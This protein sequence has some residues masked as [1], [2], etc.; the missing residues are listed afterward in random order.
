[1]NEMAMY[2]GSNNRETLAGVVEELQR[3]M[4]SRVIA[5][6]RVRR[7]IEDPLVTRGK[8][9]LRRDEAAFQAN[10]ELLQSLINTFEMAMQNGPTPDLSKIGE[11][12]LGLT[13]DSRE[14]L[15]AAIMRGSANRTADDIAN[16][17]LANV[18][19]SDLPTVEQ[20]YTR[21]HLDGMQHATSPIKGCPLCDRHQQAARDGF[22][23]V[24]SDVSCTFC[25]ADLDA[26]GECTNSIDDRC[27]VSP[28]TITTLETAMAGLGQQA[29]IDATVTPASDDSWFVLFD[30][31]QVRRGARSKFLA[32]IAAIET[33]SVR[34]QGKLTGSPNITFGVCVPCSNQGGDGVIVRRVVFFNG[35]TWKCKEHFPAGTVFGCKDCGLHPDID[36]PAH[37][38]V[39]SL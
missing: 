12:R 36:C 26:E 28:S 39:P 6:G 25:G 16:D 33:L 29:G 4:R 10:I 19:L 22:E 27:T 30:G 18:D 15:A 31:M 9:A 3:E 5:V 37:K 8:Q 20:Q 14:R 38:P 17:L 21:D 11:A 13:Q 32:L 7:R 23:D 34:L 1:M 2:I 35:D 24:Y